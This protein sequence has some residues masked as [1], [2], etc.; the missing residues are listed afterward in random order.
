M[1]EENEIAVT[2]IVS[3]Y[4]SEKFIYGCLEDLTNQTIF[5]KTEVIVIDS[6]SEQNEGEIVQQFQ[7]K[8]KNINYIRTPKRETIY[9]SWN[10]GIENSRGKYITNANTDDRHRHDAFEILSR[11]LDEN[12]QLDI[13]Y[14]DQ[15]I[16]N[17][18]DQTFINVTPVGSLIWPEFNEDTLLE[19]CCL[20]PQPMWRRRLHDRGFFFDSNLEVAGDYDFWLKTADNSNTKKINEILGI[21]FQSV[22]S[23]NKESQNKSKTLKETYIVRRE[24]FLKK[25][26]NIN[27][28]FLLKM[29]ATHYNILNKLIST[30]TVINRDFTIKLQH[31]FWICCVLLEKVDEHSSSHSLAKQYLSLP[32]EYIYNDGYMLKLHILD[33]E[34]TTHG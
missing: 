1:I 12:P 14:A 5:N 3:T 13:V 8:Y 29:F 28:S 20:G 17:I 16:T 18:P 19:R 6:G 4:N 27:N 10:R 7:Q 31:F 21:Y 9:S 24:H 25:I 33:L 2:A 22:N 32:Q 11:H 34:S 30:T 26:N 23:E 15:L